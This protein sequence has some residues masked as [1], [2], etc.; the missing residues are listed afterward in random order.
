MESLGLDYLHS[1]LLLHGH[2]EPLMDIVLDNHLKSV[3]KEISEIPIESLFGGNVSFIKKEIMRKDAMN[4]MQN[5]FFLHPIGYLDNKTLKKLLK[6]RHIKTHLDIPYY[7]N[8][9]AKMID[10][11]SLPIEYIQ[12]SIFAGS[13]CAQTL[14]TEDEEFLD[15]I[16]PK[17][18]VYFTHI[19]L[20]KHITSIATTSYVH[21]ITHTQLESN[22]GIIKDYYH[23]EVLSIFMELLHTYDSSITN[24]KIDLINRI[25]NLLANFYS[26]FLYQTD[27]VEKIN[28]PSYSICSY[29][30]DIQ[31]FYSIFIAFHLFS[32][33]QESPSIIKMEMLTKIQKVFDGDLSLEEFL[34]FYSTNKENSINSSDVKKIIK[35]IKER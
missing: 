26:I 8:L 34:D 31:Y 7:Y 14:V 1:Y 3:M 22:K 10:P 12:E 28:D 32:F 16:L 2:D 21:E 18:N 20:P 6:N 24:H 11:F 4:Y 29:H 30:R 23:A 5:L 25:E 15:I 35:K 33:Y 17:L 13:L 19:T 9:S 27:Q